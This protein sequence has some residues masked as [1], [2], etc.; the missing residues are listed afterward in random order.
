MATVRI[1]LSQFRPT[2][3][4]YAQNVTRIGAV[5]TQAARLDPKPDLVVFPETATSGYFVEGG[6]KELA[7]T[8]GTLAR[9]LAAAY[10]GPEIDV[11]VGFYERFQNHIYNSAVYA[12]LGKKKPEGRHVHRKV[13]LPTYGVVDEERFVDRGQDAARPLVT[14]WRGT[15][16]ILI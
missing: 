8:A 14:Y 2:K 13:F 10:R 6:V 15:R 11:T 3:G 12:T 16:A 4:E 7:V 9:D 1:A 5:I